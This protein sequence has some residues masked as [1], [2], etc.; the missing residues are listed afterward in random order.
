MNRKTRTT[1]RVVAF[2]LSVVVLC[3]VVWT[4]SHRQAGAGR[5]GLG[6]SFSFDLVRHLDVDPELVIY[7]EAE[8]LLT[9]MDVV[10]ALAVGPDDSIYVGG[11][12]SVRILSANGEERSRIDVDAAPS[13]LA[14]DANG[15]LYAGIGNH[16]EVFHAG[17]VRMTSW[18]PSS[19]DALP[20][21]IALRDG[22]VFVGDARHEQVLLYDRGGVLVDSIQRLVLF[23]SPILGMAV[24]P[25]G[26][27]WV[28]NAGGRELRCYG[29]NGSVKKG[30]SKSGRDIGHFS[31]CCN[32]VD[33]AIR[34]DG[35]IV[36]SEK[37]IVRVKVVSPAGE[38][39]G[40]V[41]GPK[42][43]DQSITKLDIAVDS[44]GRV[45]VLDP[46]RKAVR[47]FVA[48]EQET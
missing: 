43:F 38:L 29:R 48:K 15:T 8:A 24:D 19:E 30:W 25:E 39:I 7:D 26:D 23:S 17:G 10:T 9:G 42:A 33:I 21:S 22:D 45:L 28:A 37:N 5:R 13:C 12:R 2:L 47:V 3:L 11:D 20:V 27:L 4:L 34:A 31:G 1:L 46:I 6:R 44:R 35:S 40:V 14:V 16:I 41:A 32:P 18:E 36:T